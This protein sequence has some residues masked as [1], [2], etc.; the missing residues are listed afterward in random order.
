MQNGDEI[1]VAELTDKETKKAIWATYLLV[2]Y[3][4]NFTWVYNSP[5]FSAL[6]NR[7]RD[8]VNESTS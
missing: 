1:P 7:M 6:M 5:L 2:K 8:F 3:H 4:P